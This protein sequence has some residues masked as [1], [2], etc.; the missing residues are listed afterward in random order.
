M[1]VCRPA[2]GRGAAGRAAVVVAFAG[3]DWREL[4]RAA[5][6]PRAAAAGAR[7]HLICHSAPAHVVAHI[8]HQSSITA[9]SV[10]PPRLHQSRGVARSP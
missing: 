2:R 6:P 5:P 3:A 9:Y 1:V 10:S 7:P 8:N 4:G